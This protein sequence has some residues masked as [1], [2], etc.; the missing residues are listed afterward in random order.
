MHPAPCSTSGAPPDHAAADPKISRS[1]DRA[2]Q[3][4]TIAAMLLLLATL[5]LFW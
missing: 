4:W 1:A 5:W 3:G 2:Y